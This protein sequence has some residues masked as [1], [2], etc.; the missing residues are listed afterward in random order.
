MSSD[1]MKRF[2]EEA[3]EQLQALSKDILHL[4]KEEQ[5]AV[6]FNEIL[7][8]LHSLKGSSRLLGLT[9][10]G[11]I[12]HLTED[13]V[14]L[15]SHHVE[16]REQEYID[17]LLHVVDTVQN[18]LVALHEERDPPELSG[19]RIGLDTLQRSLMSSLREDFELMASSE[20]S[21]FK[22]LN[23][24]QKDSLLLNYGRYRN[25]VVLELCFQRAGFAD[26]VRA[27]HTKL[28]E[29]GLLISTTGSPRSPAEG[30]DLRFQFLLLSELDPPDLLRDLSAYAPEFRI[31][32]RETQ[33]VP[34]STK[35]TASR[36]TSAQPQKEEFSYDVEFARLQKWFLDEGEESLKKLSTEAMSLERYP[37]TEII[38]SI[39]RSFHNLK[40]S[41]GSY[42][43]PHI[44]KLAHMLESFVQPFRSD[45]KGFTA[46]HV[47]KLLY[48]IDMLGQAFSFASEG[49][50]DE[51][52]I[53]DMVRELEE[54]LVA[55]QV[56]VPAPEPQ[57][58]TVDAKQ[59]AIRAPES[60]R[61]N[62]KR[63]DTI[64]N[65]A[66]ELSVAHHAEHF[67]LSHLM[68]IIEDQQ[69]LLHRWRT[70]RDELMK[71]VPTAGSEINA[72]FESPE[73]LLHAL[74]EKMQSLSRY[75]ENNFSLWKSLSSSLGQEVL[76]LQLQ[77]LSSNFELFDRVIRDLSLSLQKKVSI[78][79]SGGTVEV[80]RRI[81][82]ALKDPFIHLLRNSVDHGIEAPEARAAAGKPE[83]GSITIEA[84]QLGFMVSISISDDGAGIRKSDILRV[85]R[86]RNLVSEEQATNMSDAEVFRLMFRPGFS[87][88][89]HVTS[90]SGRGV[91]LD[92]VMN[93]VRQFGGDVIVQSEP[94]KGTTF[95]LLV[96]T[97]LTLARMLIIDV[98]NRLFTL[99]VT[100]TESIILLPRSAI[101]SMYGR[102]V[103][104]YQE[105]LIPVLEIESLLHLPRST[106]RIRSGLILR[107]GSGFV[108]I[109]V[110]HVLDETELMTKPLPPFVRKNRLITGANLLPDGRITLSLN[111]RFLTE[112]DERTA[113]E[114]A[115]PDQK[116]QHNELLVV[117][118]S[119][120]ARELLKNILT[121]SGYSVNLARD[122]MEA[123]QHLRMHDIDL[124][125]TDIDMPVM[126]GFALTQAV[127][128]D[129]DLHAIPVVMFT[130][131]EKE[132]VRK[133]SQEAGVDAYI[134]KGSFNQNNLLSTVE[135]LLRKERA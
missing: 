134:Q 5:P 20:P 119:L 23:N 89:E 66:I 107:K 99:P 81:I 9:D 65:T 91:G 52:P 135:R 32:E 33:T 15:L 127:R 114:T 110:P 53:R 34:T 76:Q 4:E 16:K 31:I 14:S 21:V 105:N 121:A 43:F 104:L 129:E 67:L 56:V 103:T 77:P 42:K 70:M 26:D 19:L 37:D 7:R 96:P 75:A 10:L 102:M 29:R 80:D 73:E 46:T 94:G 8:K 117:D 93:N 2:C 17:M 63:I 47:S 54:V 126:D 39:F 97:T 78:T 79:Y 124:I 83:I 98:G 27:I 68:E 113:L 1:L 60:M 106:R 87:T 92:V 123:L 25:L 111:P 74:T 6:H 45:V 35:E 38:N 64:V 55:P 95:Q 13:F 71:I 69:S 28:N 130:S 100:G 61:V 108:C 86:E 58:A 131:K 72:L 90:V 84:R 128:S 85:A 109:S 50:H 41:S 62:L 40:G 115:P 24:Q 125:L 3:L 133:R 59:A 120:I 48:G 22:V 49:R 88:R 101:Q 118:D 18:A 57:E 44:G 30:Y 112:T 82:E 51:I 36:E 11:D 132:D 12:F 122:G 116:K